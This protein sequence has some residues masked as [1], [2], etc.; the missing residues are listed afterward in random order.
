MQWD[1]VG[2]QLIILILGSV[3]LLIFSCS[4]ML[5]I[6]VQAEGASWLIVLNISM[7]QSNIKLN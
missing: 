7:T 4:F 5:S 6:T 1:W 2:N 3:N